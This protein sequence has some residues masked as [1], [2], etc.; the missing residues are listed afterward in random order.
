MR[1]THIVSLAPTHNPFSS[2]CTSGPSACPYSTNHTPGPSVCPC[3]PQVAIV[4]P[5][6]AAYY[7][8]RTCDQFE[9][10]ILFRLYSKPFRVTHTLLA[11]LVNHSILPLSPVRTCGPS[12]CLVLLSSYLLPLRVP[13]TPPTVL[14][15][16]SMHSVPFLK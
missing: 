2:V 14:V 3:N 4:V 16:P 1:P 13:H 9:C 7:F 6:C 8:G 10:P 11:E 12:M 15:A 5:P